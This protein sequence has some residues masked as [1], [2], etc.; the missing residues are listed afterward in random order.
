MLYALSK[1]KGF[2]Q[3]LPIYSINHL[4]KLSDICE[5]ME[6][7]R[8]VENNPKKRIL[9]LLDSA[10]ALAKTNEIQKSR[11]KL[12]KAASV[13][14]SLK[15]TEVLNVREFTGK[16]YTLQNDFLPTNRDQEVAELLHEI[17]S[18]TVVTSDSLV[19]KN[20]L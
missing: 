20:A 1:L 8:E 14:R 12:K 10:D 4:S 13:K 17:G 3:D 18:G 16:L 15:S 11:E 19:E 6:T 5:Q 7:W 2:Y 9:G